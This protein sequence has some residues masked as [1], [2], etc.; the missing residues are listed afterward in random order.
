MPATTRNQTASTECCCSET[1]ATTGCC[2][3]RRFGLCARIV[4][5]GFDYQFDLQNIDHE[6]FFKPCPPISGVE[7]SVFAGGVSPVAECPIPLEFHMWMACCPN[8]S[9]CEGYRLWYEWTRGQWTVC[10][11]AEDIATMAFYGCDP[12]GWPLQGQFPNVTNCTCQPLLIQWIINPPGARLPASGCPCPAAGA[13]VLLTVSS[14]CPI[15]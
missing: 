3:P 1:E 9:G 10:Q 5:D 15:V 7:G 11:C 4:G 14:T 13:S 12:W 6:F 8:Q 2:H